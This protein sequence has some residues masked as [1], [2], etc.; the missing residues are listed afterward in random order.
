M[1]VSA[2]TTRYRSLSVRGL[3]IFYREAGS[4]KAPVLLLLHGFPSSSFMF[5]DLLPLLGTRYRVIA[6]DYPGFGLSSFPARSSFQYSFANLTSVM[7]AFCD[8]MGLERYVLYVQDYGAPIGF[9]LALARPERVRALVVQNGNAYEEGLS[10]A[11]DPLK[12]YWRSPDVKNRE[13]LRGWLTAD[14]IRQQ[15]LAGVPQALKP[16]FSPDTWTLDWARLQRPENLEVQLDLFADYRHNVALYPQI[17]AY[18]RSHQPPALIA[19]GKHDPFFTLAGARA[20]RR[21]LPQ[22]ELELFDT[23]HFALETHAAEIGR[24]MLAFSRRRGV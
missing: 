16:H 4:S 8:A 7:E 2:V 10:S 1:S 15:Y 18:F 14:G 22:A 13:K 17:Q 19:W 23:G 6:P 24:A 21:D 3:E 20:Y 12:A 5:R 9:R 11:W